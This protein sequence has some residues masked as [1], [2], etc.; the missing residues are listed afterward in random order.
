MPPKSLQAWM[1]VRSPKKMKT[2]PAGDNTAELR[3]I[4]PSLN[5]LLF[6]EPEGMIHTA[7]IKVPRFMNFNN[8]LRA[9][10]PDMFARLLDANDRNIFNSGWRVTWGTHPDYVSAISWLT[11]PEEESVAFAGFLATCIH[12]KYLMSRCGATTKS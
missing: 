10:N 5:M 2:M 11:Y 9:A 8:T 1:A 7:R 12:E 3:S 4:V 6:I